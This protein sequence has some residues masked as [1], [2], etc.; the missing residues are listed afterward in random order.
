[1]RSNDETA[2]LMLK[3]VEENDGLSDY[4]LDEL[5]ATFADEFDD[6]TR[7]YLNSLPEET[8][9]QIIVSEEHG[10]EIPP[11]TQVA[12]FLLHLFSQES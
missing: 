6:K 12:S 1:M 8:L 11:D 2:V 4:T 7:D 5:K 3:I 10:V 9:R